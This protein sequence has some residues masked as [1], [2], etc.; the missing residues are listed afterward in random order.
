MIS[1]NMTGGDQTSICYSLALKA[2]RHSPLLLF[3]CPVVCV[4][5]VVHEVCMDGAAAQLL[6]SCMPCLERSCT[7]VSTP[8]M[9]KRPRVRKGHYSIE[10]EITRIL[11]LFFS[12]C[13][14]QLCLLFCQTSR[15]YYRFTWLCSYYVFIR[16]YYCI[17]LVESFRRDTLHIVMWICT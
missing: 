2:S 17:W 10:Y 15:D 11:S 7:I 8:S 12:I 13:K 4:F 9:G 5:S 16:N 6:M 3:V 1:G 14:W